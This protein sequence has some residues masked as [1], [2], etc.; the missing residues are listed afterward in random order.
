[1]LFVEISI[2]S[3]NIKT[4]CGCPYESGGV[5]KHIIATAIVWYEKL[6][7]GRPDKSTVAE[8]TAAEP[9]HATRSMINLKA[10]IVQAKIG[11]IQDKLDR[12]KE[13]RG[14]Y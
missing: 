14:N 3:K 4:A 8:K 5:C 9:A 12:Y 11:D 2:S 7:I 10:A 1:M 13:N 6:G